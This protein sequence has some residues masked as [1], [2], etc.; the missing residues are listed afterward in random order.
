MMLMTILAI[1]A[2]DFP[3]F[4]RYLAKCET[5]GVSLG[6]VSAIPMVKNPTYL[7]TSVWRKLPRIAYKMLPIIL[8]G[9]VR[10]IL[11]KGVEY[12]EHET[13]Y[14]THWNFFITLA[15]LPVLQVLLHP[16]ILN[17]PISLIAVCVAMAHQL[18]LSLGLEDFVLSSPRVN[19]ISANKEGLVSLPGYFAI[20]LIGLSV[21][22]L[23]LP[24]SPNYFRRQLKSTTT[25]PPSIR[26]E[27]DK[28]ATE[29]FSW[30]VV[31]WF[32][33]GASR[34]IN[35]ETDVSR[36]MANFQYILWIAAYN[37][38]F[39]LGYLLLDLYFFPSPLTKS[40]YSPTSKLKVPVEST[41][42]LQ[43]LGNQLGNPPPLLE[44]I[45]KNALALFLLANIA[46]GVINLSV[47]TILDVP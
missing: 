45:N 41:T 36:R 38:S 3:I 29:L 11:V 22:V 7:S 42:A 43:L 37:T 46:T 21:G 27:N 33:L 26:R 5:Y 16:L 2:V 8:L 32:L 17:M 31:W 24:P 28:T 15:L 6:V 40:V 23:I 20:Y 47:Q 4:P 25:P 35:T 12:P 9:V 18:G 44:A 34:L 13:E 14:G 10:V 19:I 39:I 1:L 30:A